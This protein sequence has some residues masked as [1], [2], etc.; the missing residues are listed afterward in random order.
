MKIKSAK[1]MH[2]AFRRTETL[3]YLLLSFAFTLECQSPQQ[4]WRS[5]VGPPMICAVFPLWVLAV[6]VP[7]VVCTSAGSVL[8][9]ALLHHKDT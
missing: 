1:A 3:R 4:I 7:D 2:L 5:S 8:C 9:F 6:S